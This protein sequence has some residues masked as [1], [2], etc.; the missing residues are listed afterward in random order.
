MRAHGSLAVYVDG[1]K[2]TNLAGA[3]ATSTVQLASSASYIAVSVTQ[4]SSPGFVAS[5]SGTRLVTDDTTWLCTS[6]VSDD[7]WSQP[8]GSVSYQPAETFYSDI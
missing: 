6:S 8:G 1:V 4:L 5:I 7:S 3:D 2:Q